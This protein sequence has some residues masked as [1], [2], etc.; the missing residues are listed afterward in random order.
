MAKGREVGRRLA[1]GAP[2]CPLLADARGESQLQDHIETVVGRLRHRTKDSI[3]LDSANKLNRHPAGQID[4]TECVQ[5]EADSV[6]FEIALQQPS[7]D[8][9]MVLI[10][11]TGNE[12]AHLHRML[13]HIQ[14]AV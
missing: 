1:T 4:V 5:R 14:R 13:S 6:K 2:P 9:D 10:G 8:A 3:N 11:I 12:S 7:I